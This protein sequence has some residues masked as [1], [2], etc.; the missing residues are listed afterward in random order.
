[1]K[2]WLVGYTKIPTFHHPPHT[3]IVEATSP[4]GARDLVRHRLNDFGKV[5]LYVIEAAR[6]YSPGSLT[7]KILSMG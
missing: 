3:A 1:M 7:G 2:Q 6:E 4:E 5:S